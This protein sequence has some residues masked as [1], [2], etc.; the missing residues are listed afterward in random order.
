MPAAAGPILA[1]VLRRALLGFVIFAFAPAAA[2]AATL[3]PVGSYVSPMF[4]TS[5]PHDPDRLFVVEQEGEIELTTPSETSTYLDIKSLV[6][7]GGERGLLSAAFPADYDQTGLFYA[8]YTGKPEGN[9][10]IDEFRASGNTV[11]PA[12]RRPVLTIDHAAFGNH[13][14]GQLQF[15]PDGFLYIATGDGGGSG[16][17]LENAQDLTSL[18]GK[19][20]RID[21]RQ[22]GGSPYTIPPGNPFGDE[23]WSYGLRNPWRFSFDR[24]TGDLLIG[25]VGQDAWEEVDYVP[26]SAGWGQGANF[27]WDCR[28]GAHEFEP[29]GCAGPFT[30]PVFEYPNDPSGPSSVT[31]GYVVRDPAVADLFGRYV[32]ADVY[33]GPVR[34]LVPATPA[35][36]DD[37]GE[38]ITVPNPSSFGE[39]ACGRVYVASLGGEVSRFAGSASI[40]C[41]TRSLSVQNTGIGA[42]S[43]R[44]TGPGIDCLGDCGQSFFDGQ[45]VRL[46]AQPDDGSRFV[47]W[48]GACG[49][50][51]GCALTLFADQ[52]V[53]AQFERKFESG[54]VIEAKRRRIRRGDRVRL[55]LQAEPCPGRAG[56]EVAVSKR[57][58]QH[59][60][61]VLDQDC[62]AHFRIRPR[63][64]ASFGAMLNTDELHEAG[65]ATPVKIKV[66]R[67]RA[68]RTA[69][70]VDAAPARAK[71]EQE[72]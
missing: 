39:D 6:L 22:A 58:R 30:E 71:Q 32:Y 69:N 37:R 70:G 64:T 51:A 65:E 25:D 33:A 20:L 54:L 24:S 31:G 2:A 61:H 35:A 56:D 23:I 1:P 15:G 10:H 47:G 3:E 52:T 50:T 12:T 57:G 72:R 55:E 28:E 43:G 34:S 53:S 44:V 29:A 42:G 59:S 62:S 14:G 40:D 13:N 68:G 18:L 48:G 5:D 27:G 26:E 67:R 4:V 45:R 66:R 60:F 8:F 46:F 38:G 9:I 7:S 21:P 16:D 41:L 11:D 63:R 17:E 36:T 19:I 49:G